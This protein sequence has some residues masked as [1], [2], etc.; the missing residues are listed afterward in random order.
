MKVSVIIVTWNSSAHI[1]ACLQSIKEQ[2]RGIEYEVIV[3]DNDSKD[4]TADLIEKEFPWV[5]LVRNATNDGFGRANNAGAEIATG[6]VFFFL[7]DDT[8]LTENSIQIMLEHMPDTAGALG[9]HLTFRDGSHQDSVRRDPLLADQAVILTKMHNFF[10]Q[11]IDRYLAQDMDYEHDQRVDQLMG[12]C[13]MIRREVFERAGGFDKQFFIWFEEVDLLKRIRESGNPIYYTQKTSIIHLKGES[14]G[15]VRSLK[16]QML[17]QRSQR[18]YFQKHHG[19]LKTA[20]LVALHPIGLLLSL[21][22]EGVTLLG[23][24]IK[25]FKHGQS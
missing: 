1:G 25:K 24:N 13:M 8:Q 4:G 23:G 19:M 21:L 5:K 20:A 17:F 2:T 15:K 18:Q 11:L 3:T 7:N 14:F 6:D 12:A 10:P 16:K 22:V 9:C